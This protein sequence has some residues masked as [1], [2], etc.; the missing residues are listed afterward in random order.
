MKNQTTYSSPA[1]VIIEVAIESGIAQSGNAP[2]P[3]KTGTVNYDSTEDHYD[4]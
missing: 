1:V 4:F 3:G 2:A